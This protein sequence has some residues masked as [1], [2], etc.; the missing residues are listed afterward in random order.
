MMAKDIIF[1]VKMVLEKLLKNSKNFSGEIQIN[2]EIGK[3]GDNG[4]P[5][6]ESDPNHEI[7]KIF[8]NLANKIKSIYL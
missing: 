1:L 3:Q 8:L 6:V 2:P 4:V 5:I 7:S